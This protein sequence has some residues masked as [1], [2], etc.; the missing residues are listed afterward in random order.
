[1]NE[2]KKIT[3][4]DLPPISEKEKKFWK[5]HSNEYYHYLYRIDNKL[6]G[7]Y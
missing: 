3:L 6:N 4:E 2:E 1:M 5:E 7:K